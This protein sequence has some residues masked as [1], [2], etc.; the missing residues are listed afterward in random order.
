VEMEELELNEFV[1]KHELTAVGCEH[2]SPN[3]ADCAAISLAHKL[4]S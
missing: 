2:A 4:A 3:S 1:L